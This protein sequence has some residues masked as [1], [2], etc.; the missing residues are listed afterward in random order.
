MPSWM[1]RSADHIRAELGEVLTGRGRAELAP[2]ELT[3][4]RRSGS[5][6]RTCSPPST[7]SVARRG[8]RPR[9]RR[10]SF[11]PARGDP[12]RRARRSRARRCGR[13][14]SGCT[15]PEAPAEIWLKLENLQPIGSFKIRGADERDPAARRP[16]RSRAGVVT[17]SAGQHGAGRRLGGA[18]G[19]RSGDDRRP[20]ARAADEDRR[21]RAARRPRDQG[22]ARALVAGDRGARHRRRRGPVRPPGRGRARSWPGTARSGSRCSRTCPTPDAVVIP[23]GGGGPDAGIASAVKALRPETKV[24]H[25]RAG[26]RRAVRGL[27]RGRLAAAVDYTPSFVD[28]A[29]GRSCCRRC[30]ARS[31]L[32]RRRAGASLD[33]TAAAVRLL[34][35]RVRVIA[36]GAGAL[37]LA[38]ALA[39][40]RGHG[41]GRVHRVRRQHRRL[42]ARQDPRPERRPRD[43]YARSRGGD[44]DERLAERCV[45]VV[46]EL[47]GTT[48]DRQEIL[49]VLSGSGTLQL[50]R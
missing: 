33:E 3:V 49:Y 11:D 19:R 24:V 44:I 4:F 23:Y 10:S 12:A 29:G 9:A 34:A 8:D 14:S 35:E 1:A 31:E 2:E 27:V 45:E 20:R 39:G 18:G 7:S 43:G 38:A 15:L 42:P 5:P 36:E 40:P 13:R 28:G 26:D 41:Q 6:S 30:G 47:E 48:G 25:G 16:R 46:G 50:D 21:D 22:A 17:A 37:A 32:R